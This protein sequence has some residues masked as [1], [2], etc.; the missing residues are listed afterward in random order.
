M[1]TVSQSFD[2]AVQHHQS[3]QLAEA[4]VLYRQI[5]AVQPEHADALHM[6]GVIAHQAGQ[7]D[8]AAQLIRQALSLAPQNPMAHCNLGLVCRMRGNREEAVACYERALQLK[9]DYAEAHNNLGISLVELGRLDD[10]IDAFRRALELK[11]NYPDA[12]VNLGN[13]LGDCGQLDE[14]VAVYHRALALTPDSV[15]ALYNFGNTLRSM[16]HFDEAIETFHRALQINPGNLTII[17][18]IILSLH[19]KAG[20]VGGMIAEAQQR[21]NRQCSDRLKASIQPHSND[22]NPERRLRIGYVSPDF[23]EHVVARNLLPLF[24]NHSHQDFEVICYSGGIQIDETTEEFQRCADHWRSVVTMTDAALAETILGDRIDIL[25]DLSLH[26]SGNRLPVFARQPVP[27]QLSFAGYPESTGVEGIRYR[28]S[29]RWLVSEGKMQ[30]AGH[31]MQD[32]SAGDADPVSCILHPASRATPECVFLLD[33]FWCYDP[34]GIE[35]P[36]NALPALE[37]GFVT[38]GSLNSFIKVNEPVLKLWARVLERVDNARLVLLSDPGTQ[39]EWVLRVLREAGVEA[40]RVEFVPRL[41]RAAYLESYQRIDIVLDPFPYCGHTTSLDAFWMGV[42]VVSLAGERAASRAGLSQASNLGLDELVAFS[43]D[44]YV[45]V[46]ARLAGDLAGLV[47]LRRTL[48]SRMQASLLM[49][50]PRFARQIETAY[51]AMWRRWC[52]GD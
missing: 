3:G 18:T 20:D 46:A 23:R 35:L 39:R 48:R 14:A 4:E 8:A 30:D 32:D 2:L 44:D 1:R 41:S 38:F 28:I 11:P 47:E 43:E 21:W 52:A 29:D 22:R 6:L 40:R 12:L 16:G 13:A 10:A 42:P 19:Y 15:A 50:A 27:V 49:D 25:V 26:T 5:L 51:R 36:V 17:S 9:P 34:C 24:R 33:S 37:N 45:G 31:R 7:V